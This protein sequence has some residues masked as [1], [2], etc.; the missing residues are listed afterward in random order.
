M[1][2]T[3]S[4][5]EFASYMLQGLI[6]EGL[7]NTIRDWGSNR[8]WN[9]NTGF[10]A[11]LTDREKEILAAFQ[12]V[13]QAGRRRE[14][15][16]NGRGPAMPTAKDVYNRIDKEQRLGEARMQADVADIDPAF[17]RVEN[18]TRYL[19][20]DVLLSQLDDQDKNAVFALFEDMHL[21]DAFGDDHGGLVYRAGAGSTLS[22]DTNALLMTDRSRMAF[23]SPRS[24]RLPYNL[25]MKTRKTAQ[26]YILTTFV[27]QEYFMR[28]EVK[29]A[30]VSS[31]DSGEF[32][33]IFQ[34]IMVSIAKEKILE[35]IVTFRHG[36]SR[37][38][39]YCRVYRSRTGNTLSFPFGTRRELFERIVSLTTKQTDDMVRRQSQKLIKK[40]Q[41]DM[42]ESASESGFVKSGS[43]WYERSDNLKRAG[44]MTYNAAQGI[45]NAARRV[46]RRLRPPTSAPIGADA[47]SGWSSLLGK[48][49]GGM[50]DV[51]SKMALNMGVVSGLL[52]YMNSGSGNQM[53]TRKKKEAKRDSG[54]S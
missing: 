3:R 53:D 47:D 37:L 42:K 33:R 22:D 10:M 15:A 11:N 41:D 17:L 32:Y 44:E 36:A 23:S 6:P 29:M 16:V 50:V 1:S 49:A 19:L 31:L 28:P 27:P 2:E 51:F 25:F 35:S 8:G 40:V 4:T 48:T 7:S 30:V 54:F 45:N 12:R 38:E 9:L 5:L 21:K 46:Y 39:H 43:R 24:L 18:F 34:H 13:N 26:M 20:D 52:K 14:D